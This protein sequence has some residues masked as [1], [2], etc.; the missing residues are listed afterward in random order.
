[1]F[2]QRTD[3]TANAIKTAESILKTIQNPVFE[4]ELRGLL[5]D[6]AEADFAGDLQEDGRASP[7]LGKRP[8]RPSL[9]DGAD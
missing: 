1:M 5:E 2:R 4:D 3:K 9:G 6:L 7:V 8:R